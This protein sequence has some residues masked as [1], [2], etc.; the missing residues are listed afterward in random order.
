[1]FA[2]DKLYFRIKKL[3]ESITSHIGKRKLAS[4]NKP[5]EERKNMF[6]DADH[7]PFY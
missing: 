4:K 7:K 1:M 3:S 2:D 5:K 6:Y